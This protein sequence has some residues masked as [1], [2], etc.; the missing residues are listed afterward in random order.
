[1]RL[2]ATSADAGILVR[3]D[4]HHPR[5]AAGLPGPGHAHRLLRRL[6]AGGPAGR[7]L[8]RV[9]RAVPGAARRHAAVRGGHAGRR[10]PRP[11]T[12]ATRA[13]SH[14]WQLLVFIPIAA[15]LGGQVGYWIGRSI[16]TSMFKPNARVLKQRYLDEAHAF[17]EQRG[18][19]AI[20]LAPLRAD[21]A[22]A[23]ADHRGRGPDEL[24]RVHALQR[25]R[26][27]RVGRR[28]DA[29]RLRARPVRDHP[30]AARA[31]LHPH[32]A[33]LARCRCSSSGTSAAKPP[34][35]PAKRPPRSPPS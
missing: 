26:R 11:P 32:R 19:F 34:S 4:Q 33:G 31:D 10:A 7:R 13:T 2:S 21:R 3:H 25:H 35:G 17:F 18:P 20:V 14:L 16:G 23:G 27:G 24:R 15:V 22:D 8:H 12:T 29:A 30:E 9:R 28:P 5:A 1:M 6:G